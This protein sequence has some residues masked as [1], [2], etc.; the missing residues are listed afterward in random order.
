[1]IRRVLRIS[2]T[3]LLI[4]VVL[5]TAAWANLAISYQLMGSPAIRTGACLVFNVVALGAVTG[6]ALR[7]YRRAVLVYAAVYAVLLVWWASIHPSNDKD[8]AAA[9]AHGV[10]GSLNG[11]RLAVQN[12]RNFQNRGF[13]NRPPPRQSTRLAI[14]H[15][16]LQLAERNGLCG[17]MGA[18]DGIS[19]ISVS[20][21]G[22]IMP[23][24]GG[25][26]D[27]V[28]RPRDDRCVLRIETGPSPRPAR[29]SRR[30]ARNFGAYLPA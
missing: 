20:R 25:L 1:V 6:L 12:V 14:F 9:V 29:C 30:P 18:A 17:A 11:D 19:G 28:A 24:S 10:T 4:I 27:P 15:G 21:F 26:G 13:Q 2:G 16:R 7:R 3:F 22:R 8:W 23:W 5:F